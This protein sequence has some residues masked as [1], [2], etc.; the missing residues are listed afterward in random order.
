MPPAVDGAL[1]IFVA[2]IA[3]LTT[4][5]QIDLAAI[6]AAALINFI[7]SSLCK[8]CLFTPLRA[9]FRLEL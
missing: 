8:A 5:F 7:A 2:L 1:L 6:A 3:G 4:V 9:L